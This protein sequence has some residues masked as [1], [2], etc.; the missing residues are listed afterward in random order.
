MTTVTLC[1]TAPLA[2]T[3]LRS[4]NARQTCLPDASRVSLPT[5][6]GSTG[7]SLRGAICADHPRLWRASFRA[8]ASDALGAG[9]AIAVVS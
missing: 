7:P 8:W 6:C 4:V 5:P 2:W 3:Q 1:L 9:F